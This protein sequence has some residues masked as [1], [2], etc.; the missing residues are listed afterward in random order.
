[1]DEMGKYRFSLFITPNVRDILL[2]I[3]W[4]QCRA[5][6]YN[7]DMALSQEMGTQLTFKAVLP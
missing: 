4:Q 3:F 5:L 7:C 2:A 1:M 6:Y